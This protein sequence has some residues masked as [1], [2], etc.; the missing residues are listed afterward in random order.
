MTFALGFSERGSL[1][2]FSRCVM[3]FL[4]SEANVRVTGWGSLSDLMC[5]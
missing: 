2:E 1:H 3:A 5:F 4:L